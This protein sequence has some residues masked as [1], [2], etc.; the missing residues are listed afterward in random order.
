MPRLGLALLIWVAVCLGLFG[1]HSRAGATEPDYSPLCRELAKSGLEILNSG[2]AYGVPYVEIKVP[3]GSSVT[4]IC[5]HL[6]SLRADFTRC[7][8]R[9]AF[10]NALNPL[11]IK[12]NTGE[13]SSLEADTLK[14]P[15]DLN[16][17]PEVFPAYDASLP[18][19]DKFI[20][21]DIGKGFLALY[22]WGQLH[23]VF[24][25]SGGRPEKQTPLI[26]FTVKKKYQE[27]WSNIY[28]TWM[29]WALLIKLPYYIHGGVLPGKSDS[30]GCIRLFPEDA[31]ELYNLVEI[32]TPGRIIQTPKLELTY[33]AFFCR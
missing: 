17:V 5:R 29:P 22:A 19:D 24:P 26:S 4:S 31:E 9:I 2:I 10:F 25:V 14:I 7:R 27:H 28:D 23:R 3:L 6:P 18:S 1:F 33:P 15:L 32:G 12:T 30:A 20:L 8:N 16:I 21:V 11:Y 13:P